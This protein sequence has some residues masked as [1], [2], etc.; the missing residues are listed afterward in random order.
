[1]YISNIQIYYLDLN[2]DLTNIICN[3]KNRHNELYI[4]LLKK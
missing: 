1:M 4:L 2:A 3:V